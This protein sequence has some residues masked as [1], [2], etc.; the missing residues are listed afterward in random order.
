MTKVALAS[1]AGA[2]LEWYDFTLYNAMAA[3]VFNALFSH[4]LTRLSAPSSHSQ[5]TRLGISLVPSAA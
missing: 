2:T 5:P 3:L 1:M 4:H